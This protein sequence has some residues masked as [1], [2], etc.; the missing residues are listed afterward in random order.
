MCPLIIS[1]QNL[2]PCDLTD[3]YRRYKGIVPPS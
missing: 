3:L 1:V 2:T